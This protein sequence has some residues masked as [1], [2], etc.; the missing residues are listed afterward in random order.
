MKKIV[1]LAIIR[2]DDSDPC[3]FGLPIP[4]GCQTAGQNIDKMF[5]LEKLGASSTKDELAKIATANQRLHAWGIMNSGEKPQ[6]CKYAGKIFPEQKGV[7]C[8]KGDTAEGQ[9]EAGVL[10]GSPAYSKN[11]AGVSLDGLYSY[12]LGFLA[13]YNISRNSFYGI[14]S[15]S[16]SPIPK[17][18]HKPVIDILHEHYEERQKIL[19]LQNNK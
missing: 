14:Y 7:D 13:D 1:K 6:Q 18:L 16:G 15:I 12:P 2:K 8:N 17:E 11:F 3:P 5:P 10:L 19:R 9:P 4:F